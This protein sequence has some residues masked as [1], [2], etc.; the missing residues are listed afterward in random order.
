[1]PNPLS[2]HSITLENK[3]KGWLSI[4]MCNPSNCSHCLNMIPFQAV[5]AAG[6]GGFHGT[7]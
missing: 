5:E 7:T 6:S 1:M 2:L 4:T 3:H